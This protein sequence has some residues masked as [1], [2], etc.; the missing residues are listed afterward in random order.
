MNLRTTH[1]MLEDLAKIAF[2]RSTRS[3]A[4]VVKVPVEALKAIVMDH[5]A[6]VARL[7]EMGE[8]P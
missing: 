1:T 2:Q 3:K 6:M 5:G 7:Q 4:P 8:E